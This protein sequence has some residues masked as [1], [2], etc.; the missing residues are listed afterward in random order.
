MKKD[1]GKDKYENLVLVYEP[2]HK[3]IHAM[4]E[5]TIDKYRRILNLNAAQLKKLN[6]YRTAIGLQEIKWP[7]VP[8]NTLLVTE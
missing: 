8:F 1:G 7:R 5:E 2:V 4:T 3:L 6:K